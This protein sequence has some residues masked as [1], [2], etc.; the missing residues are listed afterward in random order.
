MHARDALERKVGREGPS[1]LDTFEGSEEVDMQIG[2]GRAFQ[3]KGTASAKAE[4]NLLSP[5]HRG[6]S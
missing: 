2:K 4:V 3:A 5:F 1:D 6:E